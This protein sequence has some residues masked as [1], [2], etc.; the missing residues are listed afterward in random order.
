MNLSLKAVASHPCMSD[1]PTT[2]SNDNNGHIETERIGMT[3]CRMSSMNSTK[4]DTPFRAPRRF[5]GARQT[6]HPEPRRPASRATASAV[7]RPAPRRP[8]SGATVS[9]VQSATVSCAQRRS[10]QR[11]EPRRPAS[12]AAASSVQSATKCC[13]CHMLMRQTDKDKVIETS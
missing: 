12:S 8:A 9:S 13:A 1:C 5:A 11:P 7:Q 2:N 10:V 4:Q 3:E 6:L